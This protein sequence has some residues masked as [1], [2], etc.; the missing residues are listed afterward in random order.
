VDPVAV[1]VTVARP[2]EEV[3]GYIADLANHAEFTDHFLTDWRLT[4]ENSYGEGAG[5]RFR[6]KIPFNR[7]NWGDVTFIEVD[8]PYRIV[9]AGRGGKFN[10]VRT[11]G[12]W[13]LKPGPGGTTKVEFSTET[14]PAT[15]VDRLQESLGA[16]SWLRRQNRR[17]LR[18]MRAILEEDAEERGKRPTVAA[19]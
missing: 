1:S 19:R 11:L 6:V 3:F 2:R 14:E 7:F 12:T 15:R 18:R 5:A 17:A 16:R 13:T 4:R 10:R 9:E 8:P